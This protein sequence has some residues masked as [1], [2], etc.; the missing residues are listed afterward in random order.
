MA[1]RKGRVSAALARRRLHYPVD[2]FVRAARDTFGLDRRESLMLLAVMEQE[3]F[4][5]GRD[6]FRDW[7]GVAADALDDI[8]SMQEA[9]EEI[10]AEPRERG[11]RRPERPLGGGPIVYPAGTEFEFTAETEGGTPK[12]RGR[13]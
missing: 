8:A 5:L 12:H 4:A 1:R 9:I 7:G 11:R 10:E 2:N 3:G 6:R 13:R